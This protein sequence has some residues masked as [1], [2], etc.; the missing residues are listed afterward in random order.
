MLARFLHFLPL[1]AIAVAAP[2]RLQAGEGAAGSHGAQ[3][4]EEVEDIG[5][6]EE[7]EENAAPAKPTVR[8]SVQSRA[9]YTT[10]AVLSGNNS[11]GDLIFFP[12][13]D[14]GINVPLRHHFTFDLGAKVESGIYSINDERS[15]IGYSLI[16]TLDWRPNS[17]A[18]RIYIGAE[19][20]RF[21]SFDTGDMI[22]Q[23]LGLSVG[24]DWG[25]AFNKGYSMA[26]ISYTWTDYLADPDI[27]SR[28]MHKAVV[29]LT[30]EFTPK[31]YG[32]L[33]YQFSYSDY[34]NVDRHDTRSIVGGNLTYQF[35]KTVFGSLV[36]SFADNESNESFAS[37]QG[38]NV[39][40]GLNVQF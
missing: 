22:T 32:T 20:Y 21:D 17:K 12:E 30:H 24:T 23:A 29:G 6:I 33:F 40:L 35:T 14:L 26:F 7:V 8:V 28:S 36:S 9:E 1:L 3:S 5:Q 18:P 39:S 11:E 38:F 2:V 25:V 37:Y 10:N 16:S 13:I 4:S 19:P 27:D 31:L 34:Q 15:F